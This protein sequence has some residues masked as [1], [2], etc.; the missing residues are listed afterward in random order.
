MAP[1]HRAPRP[2]PH[3]RGPRPA[4]M[5]RR[6]WAPWSIRSPRWPMP[7]WT[8]ASPAGWATSSRARLCFACGVD[9]A[10][11]ASPTRPPALR[12][13]PGRARRPGWPDRR[14]RRSRPRSCT[15]C[16]RRRRRA[17]RAARRP[18]AVSGRP[19]WPAGR[20]GGQVGIRAGQV[21]TQVTGGRPT[22]ELDHRGVEA[23]RLP[24]LDL[25]HGAHAVPGSRPPLARP[26]Q[27]PPSVHAQVG[28][29]GR[30]RRRTGSAGACPAPRPTR[31]RVPGRRRTD[32]GARRP[33]QLEADQRSCRPAPA[34]AG[35]PSGGWCRPRARPA[36]T[37]TGG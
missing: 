28:A 30:R 15:R 21:G 8:S 10:T 3:R 1:G 9:P 6:G 36:R 7:C 19:G 4:T 14:R 16:P 32:A 31:S 23:H 20:A 13:W 27:T 29:Q 2:R 35:R 37:A 18:R 22:L 5:R 25:D 26:G 33:G 24:S 34:A 11:P 17:G 12:W